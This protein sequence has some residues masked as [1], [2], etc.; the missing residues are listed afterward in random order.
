LALAPT[1]PLR[2]LLPDVAWWLGDV[3]VGS[4]KVSFALSLGLADSGYMEAL[5][6]A[7]IKR[8]PADLGILL[9]TENMPSAIATTAG[10]HPIELRDVL[11]LGQ[12]CLTVDQRRLE[13]WVRSLLRPRSGKHPVFHS[14]RPSVRAAVLSVFNKRRGQ[15]LPYLNKSS[16]A[17]AIIRIWHSHF[18]DTEAPSISTVRGHLPDRPWRVFA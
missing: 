10:Y 4:T 5:S 13:G 16:E 18:P 1:P 15:D 7:L 8:Q 6:V 12:N 11:R 3:D 17:K 14:G 9:T 2:A